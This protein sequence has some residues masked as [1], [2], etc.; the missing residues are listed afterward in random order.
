MDIANLLRQL[1][2]I[3]LILGDFNL[4]HPL[5]GDSIVSQKARFLVSL[6]DVY[7]LGYLNS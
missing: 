7:S 5:W 4:R 6:L 1:L 2:T 3:V